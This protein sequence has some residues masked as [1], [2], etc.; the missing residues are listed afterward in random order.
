MFRAHSHV[1]GKPRAMLDIPR[2]AAPTCR[3]RRR[4]RPA[5]TSDTAIDPSQRR[6][7]EALRAVAF[8]N[9]PLRESRSAPRLEKGARAIGGRWSRG[10]LGLLRLRAR[11]A[12]RGASEPGAAVRVTLTTGGTDDL[13][14]FLG[15]RVHAVDGSI[16]SINPEG[17]PVIGVTWVQLVDGTRQPWMGEGVVTVP[18]ADIADV[19]VHTLDRRKS[20]VA[21]A[22]VGIALATIAY[23]ALQGGGGNVG[24][25]PV[26][27]IPSGHAR[28]RW[29]VATDAVTTPHTRNG[30]GLLQFLFGN[31]EAGCPEP[32]RGTANMTAKRRSITKLIS[33]LLIALP[34]FGGGRLVAQG[35]GSVQGTVIGAAQQPVE[36]AVVGVV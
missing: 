34:M 31:G 28:P 25:T 30:A 13:G 20:Y 15:P 16:A 10:E 12:A 22:I 6:M 21:A 18:P 2:S 8:C 32:S 24:I 26:T 7:S 11:V 35:A 1:D 36:G 17:D 9:N 29:P 27:V 3:S 14:R 33:G 5:P 19:A 4:R 23:S